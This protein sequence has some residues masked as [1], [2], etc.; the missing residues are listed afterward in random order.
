M[1]KHVVVLDRIRTDGGTQPRVQIDPLVVDEYANAMKMG[2]VFDPAVVFFDGT[3]RWLADGFHRHAAAKQAGLAVLNCCIKQ[4]TRRD[5]VL[6]SVGAN[7]THGVRRTN[8]DKRRAVEVL[9][10]DP[11]WSAWSDSEIARRCAVSHTFVHN[12]RPILQPLQ[13]EPATRKVERNGKQY[14]M[15]TA[16]IGQRIAPEARQA[17]LDTPLRDNPAELKQLAQLSK[18]HQAAAVEKVVTGEA[19]TVRQAAIIIRQDEQIAAAADIPDSADSTTEQPWPTRKFAIIYA[20][21]P[22]KYNDRRNTHTRFCGGAMSHYPVMPVED[23]CALPVRELATD[24]AY[25]FLW[26]TW[27]TLPDALRVMEAWGFEYVTCAFNWI[28]TN[29]GDGGPFFG[30]G[31]YTKSNSEVCL[32]GRRGD[33]WKV[34]DGVSQVVQAPKQEHSRKPAEVRDRIVE[35]C[36]DRPRIELFARQAAPGWSAWGNQAPDAEESDPPAPPTIRTEDLCQ[37]HGPKPGE[38]GTCPTCGVVFALR[39]GCR[40]KEHHVDGAVCQGSGLYSKEMPEL[41]PD[42]SYVSRITLP[43]R[44]IRILCWAHAKQK[45]LIGKT[46]ATFTHDPREILEC[47]ICTGPQGWARNAPKKR[48]WLVRV[49]K[50]RNRDATVPVEHTYRQVARTAEEACAAVKALA[51]VVEVLDV[52]PESEEV[53]A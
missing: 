3:D 43:D 30:I 9:L 11:E 42:S 39:D 26:V 35:L 12:M 17:L 4:G 2:T 37:L 10:G 15:R 47:E 5:A 40:M 46:G 31:Y 1:I 18:E 6:Y 19:P 21:P 25:L 16:S 8:D 45:R 41:K 52:N 13:D 34:S 48:P 20:D 23:I 22:W 51:L 50:F 27:P 14:T 53:P 36:G 24:D 44:S 49:R 7:A 32:L 28:K 38:R 33:P 29:T